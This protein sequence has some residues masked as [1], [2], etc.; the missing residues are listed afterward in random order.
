MKEVKE[1]SNNIKLIENIEAY[2][3]KR[4]SSDYI[5]YRV[6]SHRRGGFLI[7]QLH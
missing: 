4:I 6:N 2:R 7:G 1:Q 5:L 3:P